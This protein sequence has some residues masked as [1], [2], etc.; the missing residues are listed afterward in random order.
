MPVFEPRRMRLKSRILLSFLSISVG[1]VAL[2]VFVVDSRKSQILM[3]LNQD[4]GMAIARSLEAASSTDLLSYDYVSLQQLADRAVEEEGVAHVIILD[5]EG[6]VAGFS[7]RSEWQGKPIDDSINLAAHASRRI[8]VQRVSVPYRG[9]DIAVPVFVEGSSTKW[10]TVRVGLSLESMH[11]EAKRTRLAITVLGLLVLGLAFMAAREL[12]RRITGPLGRV[13]EATDELARGNFEHRVHVTT[14]DEIEHL[15]NRFNEMAQQ[16]RRQQVEV[17]ATNRELAQLNATLEAK[18]EQRTRALAE[19]EE[20]YRILVEF[21][22]DP[23]CIFQGGSL[24][25]FNEALADTFGYSREELSRPDFDVTLLV[26]PEDR[27]S[28]REHLAEVEAGGGDVDPTRE[29]IGRRVDG[30]PLYL[31]LRTTAIRLSGQPALETILVDLTEQRS[32]QEK[33]VSYERLSALGEM[34]SGVA[35]DFNNILG[36]ILARAQLLQMKSSEPDV[37]R[38]LQIIEKAAEDGGATVRRIQDFTRVRSDRDFTTVEVGAIVDDVLEMTRS[39]WEDQAQRQGKSIAV[40]RDIEPGLRVLGSAHELREVFMNLVLNA[41]DAIPEAGEIRVSAEAADGCARIRVSDTGHGMTSDVQRRL[42]DPFF[43]TKGVKGTG[44]GMSI[45]YGI[46]QRHGGD[47]RV[48]SAPNE[49]TTFHMELPLTDRCE[50]APAPA[51]VMTAP[52]SGRVLVVDDEEGLRALAMD[53]L[54]E[55]GY[56]VTAATGGA[57]AIELLG[58]RE[59]DVIITDLGMPDVGGWEVVAAARRERPDAGIILAT[60][61]GATLQ[62][63]DAHERGVDRTLAKPYRMQDLLDAVRSLVSEPELRK[64]A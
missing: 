53:I 29:V 34:A 40:R 51:G 61:W 30:T 33:V 62:A 36:T 56:E 19:A 12:S 49:G 46:L 11:A 15:A 42:F 3:N 55:A 60:G 58:S 44:L 38:G 39:S 27:E 16:I 9:L 23:I 22:P 2:V 1:A 37:I 35:H 63:A 17:E 26:D 4:R 5:K 25:F 59:F 54:G 57:E 45:V 20:K 32:L 14:G 41:V 13:V 8:L 7:G 21:S 43:S 18:V 47:I 28:F 31:D 52:G 48:E 10:G 24:V 6:M 50:E 64:T